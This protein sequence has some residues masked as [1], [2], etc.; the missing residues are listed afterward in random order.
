ME[1]FEKCTVAMLEG[2]SSQHVMGNTSRL[3]WP[4][5][6]IIKFKVQ[7]HNPYSVA[8]KFV[9]WIDFPFTNRRDNLMFKYIF[10]NGF[11]RYR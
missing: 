5:S 2:P 8:I 9:G 1:N 11:S 7:L 3:N 10:L 4:Q 6:A